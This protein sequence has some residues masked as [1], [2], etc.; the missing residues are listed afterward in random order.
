M[1]ALPLGK[2]KLRKLKFGKQVVEW[3]NKLWSIHRKK[4][5]IKLFKIQVTLTNIVSKQ[6]S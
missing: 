6:R 5:W 1:Q 2:P 4:C 3:I